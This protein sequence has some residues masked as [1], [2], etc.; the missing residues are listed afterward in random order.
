MTLL[1]FDVAKYGVIK[2]IEMAEVHITQ[3]FE[4]ACQVVDAFKAGGGRVADDAALQSYGL[5]KQAKFGDAPAAQPEGAGPKDAAKWAAWNAQRGKS[6]D[7]AKA[8]YVALARQHLPADQ[9]AN[10]N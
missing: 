8:E 1:L 2:T 6:Q 7:A 4:K 5:F 9:A 3:L 10:I